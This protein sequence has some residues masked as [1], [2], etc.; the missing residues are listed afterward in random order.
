MNE[1][2][3]VVNDCAGVAAVGGPTSIRT[4]DTAH[5]PKN[6]VFN[7]GYVTAGL[8][9]QLN[10]REMDLA[11]ISG[12]IFAIDLACARGHGDVGW[13]RAIE[14]HI[15]AR[16]PDYWSQMTPRLEALFADFTQDRLDLTFHQDPQPSP[17]PRQRSAP[18][19]PFDCVALISGGV[20]SYAGGLV[21]LEDG[22]RPLGV[23]HTAA[24]A[25]THAQARVAEVLASKFPD[26]E[27]VGLTAQK[28]GSTFPRPEPSQRSRSLLFLAMASIAAAVGGISDVFI[29]E[30]GVMAVHI[31]MT[32]AR[33]GSLSTHTASPAVLD[34]LQGVLSDALGSS[35]HISNNLLTRTKPEVV[36]LCQTRGQADDLASTVSCWSIGRTGR[37]CGSCA[38]CLM[39]RISFE[40]HGVAD[41]TYEL[42]AFED[43]DTLQIEFA[44]D[45]LTHLVRVI[46]DLTTQSDLDLQLSYP[47]LLGGGRQ[48]SL[49]DTIDLHRRW[50]REASAVLQSHSVPVSVQ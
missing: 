2:T 45:N 3:V 35:I 50:A 12:S 36:A 4:R 34:R 20:D 9:R 22:R 19:Q 42:D 44:C 26:F 21:L 41:V 15:P 33:A 10:D 31:P 43:P 28:S 37:H 32:A 6:F 40:L 39:R 25:I 49:G 38:P 13:G 47:E 17:A 24:G 16:D 30:N 5:G 46:Q 14:A 27:R 8:P 23:S 29:N 18:F 1:Y 7:I 48:L 11:E